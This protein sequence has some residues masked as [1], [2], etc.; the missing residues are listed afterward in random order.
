MLRFKNLGS[1][2]SGNCTLVEAGDGLHSTRLLVD[3]G[4]GVRELARRVERA[5]TNWAEI[6]GIFITHEHSDHI[7]CAV[8]VAQRHNIPLWMSRGT[9]RGIGMP[10][11]G[12]LLHFAQDGDAIALGALQ[13]K[14]FTVPHDAKEPL[15]LTLSDGAVRLGILTDLG[16]STPHVLAHLTGL[17]ALLLETNHDLDM[18]ANGPYPPPLRKRIAGPLGHLNNADSAQI[19]ASVHHSGLKHLV[20]AHLSLQ[21]NSP[22]LAR[23]ALCDSLSCA[24]KDIVVAGAQTGTEWLSV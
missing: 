12:G 24:P 14:P 7:G 18:L 10:S 23:A 19:A 22:E 15:Q 11:L 20:A 5:G 21:N 13:I 9:Y 1:G 17:Q 8:S 4:L 2:S 3:C 6:N 16:Q